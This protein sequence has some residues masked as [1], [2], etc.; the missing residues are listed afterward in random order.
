MDKPICRISTVAV[1]TCEDEEETCYNT[2]YRSNWRNSVL[3]VFIDNREAE[4]EWTGSGEQKP[5]CGRWTRRKAVTRWA[6][7]SKLH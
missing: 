5:F 4:S 1:R 6:E 7:T 3:C 2:L